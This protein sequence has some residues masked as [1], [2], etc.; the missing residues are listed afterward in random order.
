MSDSGSDDGQMMNGQEFI[1]GVSDME[2]PQT[3]M[4]EHL[5]LGK[6]SNDHKIIK[7]DG[8][9]DAESSLILRKAT[10]D[11]DCTDEDR[12]VIQVI[13]LDHEDKRIEGT[14]CSLYLKH[15]DSVDLSGLSVS[16]P[17]AFKLV[18]GSGPITIVANLMKEVDNS[19]IPEE[20]DMSEEDVEDELEE[21]LSEEEVAKMVKQIRNEKAKTKQLK[22]KRQPEQDNMDDS[23][24]EQPKKKSKITA[25]AE[26]QKEAPKVK[27]EGGERKQFKS[28]EEFVKAIKDFKG[29]RPKKEEKFKNWCK[30]TFKCDKKDWV[31]QAWKAVQN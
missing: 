28:A 18:K 8:C 27:K 30:H 16:P 4:E 12:H 24:D 23:E 21:E 22:H 7:F 11:A 19:L 17:S 29:G 2:E 25:K 26:S 13:S 1:P 9:D 31:S 20:E 14:L 5:W 10:L 6:L 3:S 15:N